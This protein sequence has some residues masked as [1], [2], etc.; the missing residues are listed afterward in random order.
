MA[1]YLGLGLIL[2][3]F[4]EIATL[5]G[6][7]RQVGAL[8]VI[9]LLILGGMTGINLIRRSGVS[10][11][12]LG[13]SGLSPRMASKQ[14]AMGI[15]EFAAGLLFLLPGFLSDLAAVVLLLPPVRSRLSGWL[16]RH[17]VVA[18]TGA[19]PPGTGPIIEGDGVEVVEEMEILP[20]PSPQ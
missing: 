19:S 1:R 16:E 14:A 13:R 9:L 4:M 6:V 15:T 20:P 7:G 5:V 12:T 11:V 17:M 3:G 2:L 18:P 8:G 10:V